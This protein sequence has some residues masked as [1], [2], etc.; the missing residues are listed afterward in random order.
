MATVCALSAILFVSCLAPSGPEGKILIE[1]WDFP[2][3]PAVSKYVENRIL[4]FE[5]LNPDVHVEFTRLSWAKGGERL[6][7]AAF[8]GRPPDLT[9]AT[10]TMKYVDAGLIAPIDKYLEEPLPEDA[11]KTYRQD[12]HP[13]VLKS[14][15]WEGKTYGFP[16]YKEGFVVLL[17]REILAERGVPIP[18]DGRWTW[19]EFLAAMHRLTFDRDGD[20][21]IDV[22]GIGFNTGKEKLETF[23]FLFGDGAQIVSDDGRRSLIDSEATRRGIR[24]LLAME[25]DEKI[26]MPGAGGMEDDVTWGSF[27]G[28][29]RGLAGVSLG[30]WAVNSV[31]I[32]NR[33]REAAIAKDPSVAATAQPPLNAVAVLF[34]QMPG[35][36]QRMASYGVGCYTVFNRPLDPKRTEMAARLGRFITL[37]APGQEINSAAGLLP[38]RI[39]FQRVLQD[40]PRFT[41]ILP[42]MADAISPPAHPVWLQMDQIIGEQLQLALLKRATVDDA[43]TRMGAGCQKALDDYWKMHDAAK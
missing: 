27:S 7:I 41:Y 13:G 35:E 42:F 23:P 40:D 30:L 25:Y 33:D 32:I 11:T 17:N 8:A 9:G 31:D 14:M 19:D 37:D 29:Q 24:R 5:K 39:S 12:I 16:W 28:S 1:F 18:K 36:P 43:V 38:S 4:E 20:G 21:K 6:D 26:S 15:Q 22:Y 2:R 34:P 10:L 3:L